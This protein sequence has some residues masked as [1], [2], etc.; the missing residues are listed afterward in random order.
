MWLQWT[1]SPPNVVDVDGD[2]KNEVV[3]IPNAEM[4]MPYVTQGYAFMV[5][6][7]AQ[8]AGAN[9]ARRLPAFDTLPFSDQPAVRA[10]RRL[11]PARAASRR[12]R[13]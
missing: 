4:G 2:G 1:A 9:S 3:G 13:R 5:L 12:R 7:G 10:S 6:Q 8:D 11:L